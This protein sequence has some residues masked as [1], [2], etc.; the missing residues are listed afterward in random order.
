[1]Y[2]DYVGACKV[3]VVVLGVL[4][5][6]TILARNDVFDNATIPARL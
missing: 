2:A 4:R 6:M 5:T 1:M 3:R